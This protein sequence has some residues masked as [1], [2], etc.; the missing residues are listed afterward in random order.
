[1]NPNQSLNIQPQTLHIPTSSKINYLSLP[2]ILTTV[3]NL[4][5]KKPAG[6]TQTLF[7]PP[8][9][10]RER[11]SPDSRALR[12]SIP[13][14]SAALTHTRLNQFPLSRGKRVPALHLQIPT[15]S[16]STKKYA[17]TYK[18][19]SAACKPRGKGYKALGVVEDARGG[20]NVRCFYRLLSDWSPC[21]VSGFCVDW[22]NRAFCV[23]GLWWIVECGFYTVICP[24][25]RGIGRR[26]S[27]RLVFRD[28]SCY[29]ILIE[30]IL[31]ASLDGTLRQGLSR[32]LKGWSMSAK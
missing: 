5:L 15:C 25:C 32:A 16:S 30:N 21:C 20:V 11:N 19:R 17:R 31:F 22:E 28:V 3:P 9:I 26:R 14:C 8:T 12:K 4:S 23:E 13:W 2:L 6:I 1:M 29:N 27:V 10:D 24:C 7:R 18:M